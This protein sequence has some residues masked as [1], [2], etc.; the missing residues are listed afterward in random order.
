MRV[1]THF[2]PFQILFSGLIARGP[3]R[4]SAWLRD[5]NASR[6]FEQEANKMHIASY[7]FFGCL[8][9]CSQNSHTSFWR[10]SESPLSTED[11]SWRFTCSKKY[12]W[13]AKRNGFC[14]TST[15]EPSIHLKNKNFNILSELHYEAIFWQH[16]IEE[17]TCEICAD[18]GMDELLRSARLPQGAGATY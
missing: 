14:K 5:F 8:R 9:N 12:Y 13:R 7:A 16:R 4:F 1:R 10:T 15:A 18:V 11:S 2:T 3:S 17:R 6:W